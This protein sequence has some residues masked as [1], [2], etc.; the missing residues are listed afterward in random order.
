[1]ANDID[2]GIDGLEQFEL[3]GSGGF[4]HAYRAEDT[5]F[6]RTVAVKVL[7]SLNENGRRRFDRERLSM[8]RLEPHP[9]I[10][11]PLSTG[12]SNLGNRPFVVMEYLAG[13][14][15]Q[16]RLAESGPLPWEEAVDIVL[17]IAEA[18][19]HIHAGGV[20]HKDVKPANILI[21]SSGVPKLADFGIASIE[22][23]TASIEIAC[24]PPYAPPETF[25]SG[26]VDGDP[27]D[28]RSDLYSLAATLYALVAGGP[29]HDDASNRTP[30]GYMARILSQPVP[31]LGVPNLDRFLTKAMAKDPDDR[32]QS[33]DQFIEELAAIRRPPAVPGPSDGST[34]PVHDVNESATTVVTPEKEPTEHDA[35]TVSTPTEPDP[36]D[37][38]SSSPSKLFTTGVAG[39]AIAVLLLVLAVLYIGRSQQASDSGESAISSDQEPTS[40]EPVADPVDDRRST[41]TTA[42]SS[43][44]QTVAPR[45]TEPDERRASTTT[46]GSNTLSTNTPS[47][48]TPSTTTLSTNTPSTVAAPVVTNPAVFVGHRTRANNPRE[49]A[50]VAV[51][52][53]DDGRLATSSAD[54]TV[55]VWEPGDP[56]ASRT[57]HIGHSGLVRST[58][59]LSDGRLAS[60]S[61]D[62][63]VDVWDAGPP[64]TEALTYTGHSRSVF[65]LTELADGRIASAGEEPEIHIWDSDRPSGE[66]TR[67]TGH[68]SG[69]RAMV[70]LTDGRIASAGLDDTVHIWH[71]DDLAA[72]P[73]VYRG[74]KDDVHALV[75]LPD[76][77]IASTGADWAMTTP[78][79]VTPRVP[80]VVAG[81]SASTARVGSNTVE[82]MGSLFSSH[83]SRPSTQ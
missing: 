6:G 77:R 17:D 1:M 53:L 7:S 29:P 35:T 27:R 11:T 55:Q 72:A 63:T 73:T 32:H 68:D 52:Q 45:S 60:A 34:T 81:P 2:L 4:A 37:S 80:R 76:G 65:A 61:W 14:S 36:N 42:G 21:S 31:A 71:A 23:G 25:G 33:A 44:D 12:Y 67:Y 56:G 41:S 54:R 3:I 43:V 69:I 20:I 15:L 64:S 30:S 26:G 51:V 10:V 83:S 8:G 74:H 28:E 19:R 49:D 16:D 40:D 50:V 46:V 38:T 75:E 22:E 9:N 57:V 62:T 13:G 39:A 58:I 47:T 70:T 24:S 18:L 79:R 59:Q 5:A 78:S 66:A 82:V 48:N